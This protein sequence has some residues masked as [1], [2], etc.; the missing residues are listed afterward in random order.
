MEA[1]LEE[2][3]LSPYVADV[4]TT[5]LENRPADPLQFLAEYFEQANAANGAS[6]GAAALQKCRR[7]IVL[8]PPGTPSHMDN[9]AAAYATLEMQAGTSRVRVAEL[10]AVLTEGPELDGA[11]RGVAEERVLATL[12]PGRVAFAQFAACVKLC[13][14]QCALAKAARAAHAACSEERGTAGALDAAALPEVAAALGLPAAAPPGG[15]QGAD[16]FAAY[17]L[18]QYSS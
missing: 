7:Y 11:A 14:R 9:L 1:E 17:V 6:A 5:L 15:A 4:L 3:A 13:L 10:C 8:A 16:G 12:P 2:L 18:Q